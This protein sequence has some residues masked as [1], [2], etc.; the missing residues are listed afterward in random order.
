MEKVFQGLGR[1]GQ[2]VASSIGVGSS[3]QSK[4]IELLDDD[5]SDADGLA[6]APVE[7]GEDEVEDGSRPASV[8]VAHPEPQH[9]P[10]IARISA[11]HPAQSTSR[12]PWQRYRCPAKGRPLYTVKGYTITIHASDGDSSLWPSLPLEHL[13][14]SEIPMD[15]KAVRTWN[16]RIG[17]VLAKLLHLGDRASLFIT[18]SS[19]RLCICRGNADPVVFSYFVCASAPLFQ[20]VCRGSLQPFLLDTSSLCIVLPKTPIQPLFTVR[21]SKFRPIIISD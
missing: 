18:E 1:L 7:N 10:A 4:V 3:S 6:E 8:E 11:L 14:A 15:D 19:D 12:Y 5:E 9:L 17:Q 21:P 16:S 2:K 13:T 20:Q